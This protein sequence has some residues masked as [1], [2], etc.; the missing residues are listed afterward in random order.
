MAQAH[1]LHL[2]YAPVLFRP[3]YWRRCQHILTKSPHYWT[4]YMRQLHGQPRYIMRKIQQNLLQNPQNSHLLS[5]VSVSPCWISDSLSIHLSTQVSQCMQ[6]SYQSKQKGASII[7]KHMAKLSSVLER[8]IRSHGYM[9]WPCLIRC[10]W[11][12]AKI[13][14]PK[15]VL[16]CMYISTFWEYWFMLSSVNGLQVFPQLFLC[17]LLHKKWLLQLQPLYLMRGCWSTS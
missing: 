5:M 13:N 1:I 3:L 9:N 16:T 10:L 4:S 14:F 17:L 15:Y 7:N 2:C 11:S 6:L 8:F 12:G